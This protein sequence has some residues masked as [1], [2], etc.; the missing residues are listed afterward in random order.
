MVTFVT[1]AFL[2]MC[3]RRVFAKIR[4]VENQ[5]RKQHYSVKH[6]RQ[7]VTDHEWEGWQQQPPVRTAT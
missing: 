3:E 1:K 6:E 4:G 7:C 2:R 5:K